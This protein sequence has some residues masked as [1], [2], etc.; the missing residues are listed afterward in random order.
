M[1]AFH[2]AAVARAVALIRAGR[3][4]AATVAALIRVQFPLT[5]FGVQRVLDAARR[6]IASRRALMTAP[7]PRP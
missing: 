4:D 6:A 3:H 2:P 5:G 1:T 7:R